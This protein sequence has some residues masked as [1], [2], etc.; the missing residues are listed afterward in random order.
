MKSSTFEPG[1]NLNYM[2]FSLNSL[3]EVKMNTNTR[4]RAEIVP[5]NNIFKPSSIAD[6]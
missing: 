2:V 6:E 1:L 4:E 5:C 3:Q